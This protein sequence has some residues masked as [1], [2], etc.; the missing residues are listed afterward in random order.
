MSDATKV[1]EL[2]KRLESAQRAEA[3]AQAAL[4]LSQAKKE[5]IESRLYSEYE[6]SSVEDAMTLLG[7]LVA[8]YQEAQEE[9]E[10]ALRDLEGS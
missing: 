7:V 9:I 2:K 4:Q 3:T 8:D 5:E 6:I 1:F 10:T